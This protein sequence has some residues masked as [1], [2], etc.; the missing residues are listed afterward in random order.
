MLRLDAAGEEAQ[1]VLISECDCCEDSPCESDL[2]VHFRLRGRS[3]ESLENIE[4]VLT[5]RLHIRPE[6]IECTS[7]RRRSKVN[8]GKKNV[9]K[10][11]DTVPVTERDT[12]SLFGS[13]L[14][15][16]GEV[17]VC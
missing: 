2:G 13:S 7:H 8:Q 14:G 16:V 6:I 15:R 4:D 17:P 12:T 3:G 1:C 9:L 11:D 10:I 5:Y